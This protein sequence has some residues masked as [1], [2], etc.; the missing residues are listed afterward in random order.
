ML[1]GGSGPT[2]ISNETWSFTAPTTAIAA[3]YGV[4]CAGSAGTPSLQPATTPVIGSNYTLDLSAYGLN[5][6]AIVAHG[7]D[8]LQLAPGVYLPLDL[9]SA[10][11]AGCQLEV[12]ADV[13]LTETVSAGA[14]TQIIPIPANPALSGQ[15][16]FS[17]CFVFDAAA[18]NGF[19]ALSNAV[20]AVLGL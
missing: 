14:M 18:A 5:T 10:G 19:G 7:L 15:E 4:A 3:P 6:F 9:T 1:F 12:R 16:L 11:I 17:Q 13:T 8:N 20:H 2:G